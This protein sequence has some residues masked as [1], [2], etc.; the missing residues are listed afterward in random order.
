[1]FLIEIRKDPEASDFNVRNYSCNNIPA[2]CVRDLI[3]TGARNAL[4]LPTDL[5]EIRN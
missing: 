2:G 3:K 5:F 1:M 4:I